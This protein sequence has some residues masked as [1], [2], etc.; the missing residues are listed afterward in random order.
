MIELIQ[1]IFIFFIFFLSITVPLNVFNSNLLIN[2]KKFNLDIASFNLLINCNIL[3]FL[4]IIPMALSSYNFF[5]ILT[6]VFIFIYIYGIKNHQFQD[7][8]KNLILLLIFFI[9]FFIIA[10]SVANEISLGW[11]AKYFY[12]IKA[13]FFAENQILY[14]IKRFFF[15]TWHPHLGSYYWAFYWSLMP[16]EFEYFGRLFYVFILVFSLFYVCHDNSKNDFKNNIIFIL[17]VLTFY[18]YERFSGLQEILIFSFLAILSKYFFN[19][20][21][22]KNIY[23]I[24]FIILG[25]N[26]MIW[27][28]VEGIIYSLI[29]I[30][31]LNLSDEISKKIKIYST[32]SFIL[33]II[34]KLGIYQF[35]NEKTN[36]LVE[37]SGHPYYLEYIYNLN[38]NFILYKMKYII[39]Y[40]IYY[41]LNN[42]FFIL[43]ILILLILNFTKNKDT[44]I[45]TMNFYFV[46]NLCFI[47]CAYIL[48]DMEIEYSVKTTMERVIFTSSGFFV[49]LV[50]NF[51]KDFK[52]NK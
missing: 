25:C 47:F 32:L 2:K 9:I 8:K 17:L 40:L 21:Y 7:F 41:T 42:I 31:I 38:V 37:T 14:D 27:F 30:L 19:L 36:F 28:K 24:Y 34:F 50:I 12:Y 29:L 15:G 18:N 51:I 46:L 11:D 1:I 3:L 5:Y 52:K 35:F 22:S 43:G 10:I 33:L 48:R 6:C 49:F 13:L 44:Y 23:Y 4:S 39:P 45:K 26:L 16:L 20:K